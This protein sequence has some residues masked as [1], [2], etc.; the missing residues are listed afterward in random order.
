MIIGG[1]I[2]A[3]KS[4][5][6]QIIIF[7]ASPSDTKLVYFIETNKAQGLTIIHV[8]NKVSFFPVINKILENLSALK[9]LVSHTPD[10][11]RPSF[12]YAPVYMYSPWVSM[13]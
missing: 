11:T 5:E 13:F 7:I 10:E 8:D 9:M 3:F 12:L 6:I 4:P 2:R 1:C